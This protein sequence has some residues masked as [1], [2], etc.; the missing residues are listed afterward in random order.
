MGWALLLFVVF[1]LVAGF[2]TAIIDAER[3][4]KKRLD[5]FQ[6]PSVKEEKE[7][8]KLIPLGKRESLPVEQITIDVLEEYKQS[9]FPV[10]AHK[11]KGKFFNLAVPLW[12]RQLMPETEF[13]YLKLLIPRHNYE[14]LKTIKKVAPDQIDMSH[15]P[16]NKTGLIQAGERIFE[17][18]ETVLFILI[19]V[20]IFEVI[21]VLILT[22]KKIVFDALDK[23]K[24]GAGGFFI[25]CDYAGIKALDISQE[26]LSSG[27]VINLE[28]TDG[29][30]IQITPGSSIS[31]AKNIDQV[32]KII[33]ERKG[34]KEYSSS[35]DLKEFHIGSLSAK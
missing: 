20:Q 12:P 18:N 34:N 9:G 32:K 4:R 23:S 33:D 5:L 16:D 2:I 27:Q 24:G 21:G 22:A 30:K 6:L 10:L 15:L 29:D 31:M 26:G 14:H 28:L 13:S 7:Y 17:E 25:V 19:P 35:L 8:L 3:R 1:I 11:G